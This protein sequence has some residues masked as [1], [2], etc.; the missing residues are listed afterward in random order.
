MPN[1]DDAIDMQIAYDIEHE[2]DE[3]EALCEQHPEKWGRRIG[4]SDENAK[5]LAYC[6]DLIPEYDEQEASPVATAT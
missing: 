6:D 5:F 1:S 3:Y 2:N 4:L